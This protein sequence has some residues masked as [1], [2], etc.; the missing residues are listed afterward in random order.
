[1]KIISAL[2]ILFSLVIIVTS[3]SLSYFTLG[4]IQ[5]SAINKDVLEMQVQI[6][7]GYNEINNLHMRA[8]EDLVFA[9]KNPK[10]VEYFE[11]PATKAVNVYENDVLQFS[12]NQREIKNELDQWIYHFQNKFHIDETCIIDKTGQEH[13][14]LVFTE[15]ETDKDLSSNEMESPFFKPSF[16]QEQDEVYIQFPYLSPDSFRWVFAY[17]SPIVLDN[18]QKP[19]FYHFEMPLEIFQEIIKTD[20]GRMMIIDPQG[21]FIADSQYDFSNVEMISD[22]EDYFPSVYEKFS[23]EA[24]DQLV[25][26][27]KIK[28]EGDIKYMDSENKMH[29][30]S[31]KELPTFGW[32]LVYEK[33]EELMLLG[34]ID[35][36]KEIYITIALIT[37]GIT[38]SAIIIVFMISHRITRPILHLL[39]KIKLVDEGNFD[40]DIEIKGNNELTELSRSF[41]KMIK[42]V[43]KTIQLEKE[44]AVQK[45]KIK[46]EKLSAVGELTSRLS[47]DLRNPLSIIQSSVANL[48]LTGTHTKETEASFLRI[49][50]AIDRMTHQIKNVLDFVRVVPPQLEEHSTNKILESAISMLKIPDTIKL[51]LPNNDKIICCD[52]KQCEI[53]FYNLIQNSIQ[54]INNQSGEITIRITEQDK[55]TLVEFEDTGPGIPEEKLNEIFEPLYTTKQTGTG[56]GLTSCKN[57]MENCGGNLTVQINPTVFTARFSK[58]EN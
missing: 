34:Y 10:F 32:I 55:D 33:S 48:R 58:I 2:F 17:T 18:G 42:S 19:A 57:L 21:Y 1:M 41:K 46:S 31:Y 35:T 40:V 45:Q 7:Q 54:A 13:V 5:E 36:L 12:N 26:Q 20:N 6:D 38:A 28:H 23:P 8:S 52:E 22:F 43:K 50:R 14:R 24:F 53:V 47:H 44:L 29:Y 27:A 15:I 56:L 4:L 49:E 3:I 25:S 11:L 51:N 30:L 9:L 39:D 37:I 16:A